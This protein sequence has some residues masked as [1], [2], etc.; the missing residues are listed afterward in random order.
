[1]T[2]FY[3]LFG[4][5]VLIVSVV[6][7]TLICNDKV[8]NDFMLISFVLLSVTGIGTIIFSSFLFKNEAIKEFINTNEYQRLIEPVNINI[9]DSLNYI[10]PSDTNA[11]NKIR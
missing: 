9:D 11:T 10:L 1:M 2:Y 7:I 3:L 4:I 6:F 5:A 8:R